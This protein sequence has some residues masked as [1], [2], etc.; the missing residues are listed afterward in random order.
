MKK[1]NNILMKTKQLIFAGLAIFIMSVAFGFTMNKPKTFPKV[2]TIKKA[3]RPPGPGILITAMAGSDYGDYYC[4]EVVAVFVANSTDKIITGT[5]I[6]T[7][8]HL[9]TPWPN[10]IITNITTG[11]SYFVINGIIMGAATPC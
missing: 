11:N 6:F 9:T 7:N 1:I 10:G 8:S 4:A 3:V 2:G 5:P